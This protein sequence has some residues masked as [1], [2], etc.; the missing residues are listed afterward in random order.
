VRAFDVYAQTL[1]SA[2]SKNAIVD[3]AC[4]EYCVPG[5]D[6]FDVSCKLVGSSEGPWQL[7]FEASLRATHERSGTDAVLCFDVA[8]KLPLAWECT[9]MS[10]SL[11]VTL[12][13]IGTLASTYVILEV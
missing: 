1:Q 13:L 2:L 8:C 11:N 3:G 12:E 7:I 9:L 5:M 4:C 6:G 10:A